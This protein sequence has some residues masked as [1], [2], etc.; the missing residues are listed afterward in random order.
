[1][2]VREA[3]AWHLAR[4]MGQEGAVRHYELKA[5]QVAQLSENVKAVYREE[6][7][8]HSNRLLTVR[9]EFEKFKASVTPSD[10]AAFEKY[11]AARDEIR[12]S[13]RPRPPATASGSPIS[14]SDPAIAIR[15][16]SGSA[17]IVTNISGGGCSPSAESS[18]TSG[19]SWGCWVRSGG[20]SGVRI[21]SPSPSTAPSSI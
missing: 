7:A 8:A 19:K 14:S 16:G 21:M 5:D 12:R 11:D 15:T 1:M 20:G 10:F 4:L 13:V 6:L 2:S 9:A 3:Y 17:W 18:P